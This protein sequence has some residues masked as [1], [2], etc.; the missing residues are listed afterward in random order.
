MSRPTWIVRA[1]RGSEHATE[2]LRRGL[3]ALGAAELGPLSR[4]IGVD[5]LVA[6]CRQA[7]PTKGRHTHRAWA[8]QLHKFID[9][10]EVGDR[11][12]TFDRANRWYL[13]GTV[14]SEYQWAPKFIPGMPHVR[15]VTW[16]HRAPWTAL[17][18]P[19]RNSLRASQALFCVRPQFDE[20]LRAHQHPL[21]GTPR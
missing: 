19:A 18:V 4:G 2:F 11:V 16:T 12:I 6:R 1:G 3:V 21:A 13:V 10:M 14:A 15:R 5:D 7:F 17:S 20:E 9:E 8:I